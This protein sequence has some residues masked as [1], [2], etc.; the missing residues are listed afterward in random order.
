MYC[1]LHP[2][3][4]RTQTYE[5]S[6]IEQWLLTHDSSP[7][8]GEALGHKTLTPNVI[9]RGLLRKLTEKQLALT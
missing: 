4:V 2:F 1:L 7:L 6:A 8:T 9:V 3:G 5:R